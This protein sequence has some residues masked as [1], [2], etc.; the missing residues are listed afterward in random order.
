ML[1]FHIG[2]NINHVGPSTAR[3]VFK[4]ARKCFGVAVRVACLPYTGPLACA[5]RANRTAV[6]VVE[7]GL[8]FV[9]EFVPEVLL[10]EGVRA[11]LPTQLRRRSSR[12]AQPCLYAG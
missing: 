4:K 7:H 10:T 11:A 8:N 3:K 5:R 1:G 9:C 12:Y 2:P 6:S